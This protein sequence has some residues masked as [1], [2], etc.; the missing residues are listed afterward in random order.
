MPVGCRYSA[1]V[2]GWRIPALRHY[3]YDLRDTP[4]TAY[5]VHVIT[6]LELQ[7]HCGDNQVKFQVVCPQNGTVVLLRGGILNRTYDTHKKL[8]I[9]VFL[10][11]IFGPIYYGP[12]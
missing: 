8:D 1:G 11:T 2:I 12:P 4:T 10:L 6:L 7:S 9:S 3:L 5:Q